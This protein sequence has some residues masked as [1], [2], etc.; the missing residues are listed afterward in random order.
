M[1][2]GVVHRIPFTSMATMSQSVCRTSSI[3]DG[4][5][6]VTRAGRIATVWLDNQAKRNAIDLPMLRALAEGAAGLAGDESVAAVVLRG[7]GGRAFSAGA[8]FNIFAD[9]DAAQ[10]QTLMADLDRALDAAVAALVALPQPLVA[11]IEGSCFGGAVQLALCADM[12]I[13]NESM[14]LAIPAGALGVV[15]PLD[16][17]ERLT[18]LAG[19]GMTRL[20]L[21]TGRALSA[22]EC[23][24]SRIVEVTAADDAFESALAELCA[25]LEL[26][27]EMAVRA[28]KRI[29]AGMAAPR[30]RS[31]MQKLQRDVNTSADTWRRM[32]AALVRRK[33]RA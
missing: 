5:V 3:T 20:I 19:P 10:F 7:A 9:C 29:V 27:S 21:M 17:I 32:A 1:G 30:V 6:R 12:R 22:A 11:A 28:Y 4:A 25:Q 26:Q 15:Y 2:S 8:D 18:A 23:L 31:E 13:A 14:R 16:A 24:R 33:I